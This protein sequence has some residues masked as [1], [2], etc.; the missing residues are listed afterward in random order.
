MATFTVAAPSRA[1]DVPE[2]KKTLMPTFVAQKDWSLTVTPYL[3]A[4]SLNG[5]AAVLGIRRHVDV[6]FRDT[7]KDLDFGFMGNVEYRQG[8]AGAYLDAQYVKVSNNAHVGPFKIGVGMRSALVN[9]GF[10]YRVYEAGLGGNTVFGTPRVF[11]I[12]P[13]AGMRWT[14]M[15]ARV[16]LGLFHVSERQSWVDPFVGARLSYDLTDRWNLFVES[17]VG[18][19]GAGSRLS[20]NAQAVLGYRLLLAGY[21]TTL[22]VG[23]RVLKQDYRDGGFLWNVTQHGPLIGA[24]IRF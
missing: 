24:S 13:T 5:N 7:L 12:E 1:A 21:Q 17:D 3:W 20:V 22:R 10:F 18:G 14:S 15:M 11:A 9:V 4:A 16:H 19:F 23:Y 6:P 2:P 8:P